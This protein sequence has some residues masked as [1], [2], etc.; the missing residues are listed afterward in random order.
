MDQKLLLV[1]PLRQFL[2]G[3]TMA[4]KDEADVFRYGIVRK[5][6]R[7]SFDALANLVVSVTD[8]CRV[9]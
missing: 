5:V 3:E 9:M 2:I 6:Q 4:Y 8:Y 7:D 1:S